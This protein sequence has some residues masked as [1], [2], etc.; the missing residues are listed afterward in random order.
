MDSTAVNG[1]NGSAEHTVMPHAT[2]LRVVAAL[3]F[4]TVILAP[5]G[6]LLWIKARQKE[7]ERE[8]ELNRLE[9]LTS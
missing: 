1:T 4:F 8:Q 7:K 5:F 2:G 3:C 6:V 9:E